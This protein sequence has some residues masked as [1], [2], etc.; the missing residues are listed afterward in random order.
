MLKGF[1][2]FC[3]CVFWYVFL[4][5]AQQSEF[6]PDFVSS[7]NHPNEDLFA[8]SHTK[9]NTII[10]LHSIQQGS[11][12]FC[13]QDLAI[14]KVVDILISQRVGSVWTISLAERFQ[15]FFASFQECLG[16]RKILCCSKQRKCS[17]FFSDNGQ[18][19]VQFL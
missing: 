19:F 13:S 16:H 1:V 9:M 8:G 3:Q 12:G 15:F 18:C 10:Q 7:L 5:I 6:F 14:I 2:G 11:R 17:S 4:D